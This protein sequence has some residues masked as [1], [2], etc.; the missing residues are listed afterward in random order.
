MSCY[1]FEFIISFGNCPGFSSPA[2]RTTGSGSTGFAAT[3]SFISR[4]AAVEGIVAVA[5]VVTAFIGPGLARTSA[6]TLAGRSTAVAVKV[7]TVIAF[8]T[9]FQLV[10][11]TFPTVV[12][13]AGSLVAVTSRKRSFGSACSLLDCS[14][15]AITVTVT[16][17][18]V[19]A[20]LFG[21]NLFKILIK[22]INL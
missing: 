19:A 18:F 2:G 14:V 1:C 9:A 7:A 8:G 3:A 11:R 15:A 17:A 5:T 4:S 12:A 6:W 10:S 21:L 13:D 20:A 16:V 22:F